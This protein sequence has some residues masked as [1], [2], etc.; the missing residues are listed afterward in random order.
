MLLPLSRQAR[1]VQDS[2]ALGQVQLSLRLRIV[3]TVLCFICVATVL[4]ANGAGPLLW[5]VFA[6]TSLGWP[7]LARN[8]AMRNRDHAL[9]EIRSLL[10]DSVLGG[11]W[12][13]LMQFN[14]LP[15]ALL[16]VML[17]SDTV[18][19]GGWN[20]MLRGV[21]VQVAAAVLTLAIH[22]FA[23]FPKTSMFQVFVTL[24]MLIGYPLAASVFAHILP[25]SRGVRSCRS[26]PTM[27]AD[28]ISGA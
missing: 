16:T 20:L 15:S 5:G 21:I 8:W 2:T 17:A 13:A 23:F 25:Y 22:G 12:V 19:V 7:L 27:V 1:I 14:L 11:V 18:I 28:E 3:R 10:I 24:P 26:P 4:F 9:V 6:A